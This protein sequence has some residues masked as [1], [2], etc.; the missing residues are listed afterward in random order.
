MK[1]INYQNRSVDIRLLNKSA[2][3]SEH[4][5]VRVETRCVLCITALQYKVAKKI[6]ES[7]VISFL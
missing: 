2:L 4:I 5:A 6:G 7:V 3:C 1:Y